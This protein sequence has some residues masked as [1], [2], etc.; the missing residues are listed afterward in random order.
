MS[1]LKY[2]IKRYEPNDSQLQTIKNSIVSY[3]M[4][5]DSI[6]DERLMLMVS[7]IRNKSLLVC[8]CVNHIE[9]CWV[10]LN[11]DFFFLESYNELVFI[12]HRI[13][14]NH[15]NKEKQFQ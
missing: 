2:H 14:L 3:F 11:R 10:F 15:N 9:L 6:S 13:P 1:T 12:M 5:S 8:E 4:H 7:R